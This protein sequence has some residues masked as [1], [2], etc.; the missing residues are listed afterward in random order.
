M[1]L[2]HRVERQHLVL[3]AR[4]LVPDNGVV[5]GPVLPHNRPE[6]REAAPEAHADAQEAQPPGQAHV[7]DRDG[8]ALLRIIYGEPALE[9][10]TPNGTPC[11]R[12]DVDL[13]PVHEDRLRGRQPPHGDQHLGQGLVLRHAV[14]LAYEPLD[15]DGGLGCLHGLLPEA[16][17]HRRELPHN[18]QAVAEKDL[19]QLVAVPKGLLPGNDDPALG[20]FD[21]VIAGAILDFADRVTHSHQVSYSNLPVQK[22]HVGHGCPHGLLPL[23]RI[24]GR[25]PPHSGEVVVHQHVVQLHAPDEPLQLRDDDPSL[26]R[27]K[28]DLLVELVPNPGDCFALFHGV[29]DLH[30]VLHEGHL[31]VD[32]H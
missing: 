32:F 8:G 29:A 11:R 30:R 28:C 22:G 17:M 12:G 15:E 3:L 7:D 16:G 31:W 25:E 20:S 26:R 13:P 18:R 4:R 27:P 5:D 6:A 23:L 24:E 19:V 21:G 9:R 14:A 2:A 1:H 10:L